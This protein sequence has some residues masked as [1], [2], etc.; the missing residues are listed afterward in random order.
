MQQE[1]RIPIT[2]K[3]WATASRHA[4]VDLGS[5]SEAP[6][7]AETL[8]AMGLPR[9]RN[10]T[11]WIQ[12]R[13][14]AR[15]PL[16]DLPM[17][18]AAGAPIADGGTY[19]QTTHHWTGLR[20]GEP[21]APVD[22]AEYDSREADDRDR[23]RTAA[24]ST[25]FNDWKYWDAGTREVSKALG[26]VRRHGIRTPIPIAVVA[27]TH[28]IGRT[29]SRFIDRVPH[30]QRADALVA[31]RTVT[32][33]AVERALTLAVGSDGEDI[34]RR[35]IAAFH[36]GAPDG[37]GLIDQG[38]VGHMWNADPASLAAYNAVQA[39]FSPLHRWMRTGVHDR[40]DDMMWPMVA[41]CGAARKAF[42]YAALAAAGVKPRK[43]GE[44]TDRWRWDDEMQ[45]HPAYLEGARTEGGCQVERLCELTAFPKAPIQ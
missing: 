36:A 37:T 41:A 40:G 13:L 4:I 24:G 23:E 28:G 21:T 26:G 27:R 25:V 2:G 19:F 5:C 33:E 6:R 29:V 8:I 3:A 38:A 15:V 45:R 22:C 39:S 11:P 1:V 43:C 14:V 9:S 42:G 17:L 18:I 20:E 16:G 35:C 10:F 12:G 7:R 34:A 30:W 32:I 44:D 31:C